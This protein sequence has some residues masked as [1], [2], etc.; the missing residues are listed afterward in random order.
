MESG[1]VLNKD[2]QACNFTDAYEC[3][4]LTTI[5]INSGIYPLPGNKFPYPFLVSSFPLPFWGI[6][7]KV[8]E[9]EN[10]FGSC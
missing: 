3:N 8:S 2:N 7:P 4:A 6:S 1:F 5:F 9:K 10:S